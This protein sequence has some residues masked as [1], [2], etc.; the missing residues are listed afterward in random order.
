MEER[1]TTASGT[2]GTKASSG[3]TKATIAMVQDEP[4][5]RVSNVRCYNCNEK[6]H[7][8]R[9]CEKPKTAKPQGGRGGKR[10]QPPHRGGGRDQS[11]GQPQV[12]AVDSPPAEE[13]VRSVRHE[14]ETEEKEHWT[15]GI[16]EVHYDELPIHQAASVGPAR[17]HDFGTH[18]VLN[19]QPAGKLKFNSLFGVAAV[20]DTC[21]LYT[22]P[23]PRDA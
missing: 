3:T 12:Q 4:E 18:I 23:S 14:R 1:S 20:L 8:A 9:N 22:S 17:T 10:S 19:L 11:K 2:T 5:K 15:D 16:S 21:L 6:G 13:A 7:F